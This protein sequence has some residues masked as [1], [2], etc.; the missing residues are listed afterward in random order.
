MKEKTNKTLTKVLTDTQ[1]VNSQSS[2][3]EIKSLVKTLGD[4]NCPHCGGVGYVRMDVPL[5]HEKFGKLEPCVCRAKDIAEGARARLF[6]LSNL[7]RLSHLGFE[8]FN[9]DGNEKAKFMT[10]QEKERLHHA[11]EACEEFARLQK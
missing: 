1:I 9:P 5:G 7:D 10:L 2:S 8:N 11:L 4:P 6:A 3:N